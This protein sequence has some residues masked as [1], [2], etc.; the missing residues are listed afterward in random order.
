MIA[1]EE[2]L[3][4]T[5]QRFAHRAAER[6]QKDKLIREGKILDAN[7]PDLVERRMA[8]LQADSRMVRAM[9]GEGLKFAP[10]GPGVSALGYPRALERVLGTNDLMGIGF[11]ERGLRAARPV[12]RLQIRTPGGAPVGYGTGFMVSPR[13]LLTNHH[14]FESAESTVGSRAEFNFQVDPD[15]QMRLSR[16]FG[17]AP[18][19][20]FLTDA[21]LDYTLVALK[22]DAGLTGFGWLRLIEETGKVLVGE[23]VNIIQ[24]PNG[25]PKQLA[26]R[27][28]RVMDELDRFLHYQTDTAPGSSG[29]P[30]CNDQWE[31]VALH[32][33]GVPARDAQGHILT[34]DNR[35][36]ELWM[37]EQR[38][39]WKANEGV[40][41]SQLVAHVKAQRLG[42][43]QQ[44][45]RAAMF[46]AEPSPP[47]RT[48][49]GSGS[50]DDAATREPSQPP[51]FPSRPV[52][53]PAGH[54][55]WTLPL[56]IS[57]SLGDVVSPEAPPVATPAV[58]T[59]AP[60]PPPAEDLALREAL[61]E[62]ASAR[63]RVYYDAAAD[64]GRA[65]EYYAGIDASAAADAL[66]E[67][68]SR[69]LRATHRPHLRYNPARHVYSW[70]DLHPDLLIRSIYSGQSFEPERLIREDFRIDQEHAARRR[71]LF[72]RES[73]LSPQR[74]EE[75][76]DLL[77]AALPY[78]CE[79][80][81]PQSW[82]GKR[83][84]M[85]GDLHHLFAC[86]TRC[87]SFRSNIPYYDF[88]DFEEAVRDQCG[89]RGAD[90]FEPLRGKGA[91]AR[92]MLYFL[93]RYPGEI[94]DASR[95]MQRDRLPT[96]LDWHRQNPPDEYERHRNLAIFDQ[97][98]NRNPL[99]DRP[100]WVDR[101]DFPLG[102]D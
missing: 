4:Q 55:T 90:K 89:K 65:A 68:L 70:V 96:L 33:S 35:R 19:E 79:H 84:P 34:T 46:D 81:V 10:T 60:V 74:M 18:E 94:G 5:E 71:E 80:V 32:H 95:E 100:E 27:E 78:N 3:K 66:F 31:V 63:T 98:S 2:V 53:D 77:E 97:Q 7:P 41:V 40:R 22:P 42:L 102:F 14:V 9:I 43:S 20:F 47:E 73:A 44:T 50:R 48:P 1:F 52:I 36:W 28:N 101:I 30:V 17:F 25:E 64:A 75:E 82:F 69:L 92:A 59:P 72:L 86:E 11:F 54:A 24:H 57:V 67:S 58:A 12:A 45:L 21:A 56:R 93:L 99:I 26:I 23:T 85:R 6:E 61:A 91:V 76:L 49:D 51:A 83:E 39:A 37:G 62:L 13:L 15:G 87:N 16:A 88:P 38:I 29:S 8:R